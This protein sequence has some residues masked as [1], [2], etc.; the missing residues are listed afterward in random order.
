MKVDEVDGSLV[1]EMLKLYN[2]DYE[3]EFFLLNIKKNYENK[4]IYF[5][6]RCK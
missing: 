5:N 1:Y 3:R 4:K 6:F 2:S